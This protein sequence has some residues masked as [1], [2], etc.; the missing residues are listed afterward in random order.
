MAAKRAVRL[1]RETDLLKLLAIVIM[2]VDH[3]GAVLFPNCTTLR[4]IGR[5]AFPIF[6][7]TLAAGCCYSRSLGKYAL[8]LA[9]AA[10]VSQPFYALV[11]NHTNPAMRALTFERPVLDALRWYLY[12]FQA[13]NIMVVLLLGL[14]IIWTLRE[15]R[16]ALT[17]GLALLVLWLDTRGWIVTSYGWKG[18]MLIVL[19]YLFIDRPVASLAWIGGFMI[20]WAMQGRGYSFL[21]HSFGI[22]IFALTALPFIY[23][24]LDRHARVPKAVFYAFYPAHMAV[25]YVIKH[26]FMGG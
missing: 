17:A 12:S 5:A 11:L 16:F 15:E 23:F 24:P 4:V 14:L 9:A 20:W 10:L 3:I 22:Q 6:C 19:F 18:V 13:C 21:G 7:Y 25:L 8:R 26:M 1:S 2:L